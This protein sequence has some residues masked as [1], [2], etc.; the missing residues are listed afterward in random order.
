[1]T[2]ANCG[3]PLD[4]KY[5][6]IAFD[7]PRRVD[8]KACPGRCAGVVRGW[9]VERLEKHVA[10]RQVPVRR[11]RNNDAPLETEAGLDE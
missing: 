9:D 5:R 3:I 8:V 4:G 7:R 6:I 1:M 11:R 2:C 10:D